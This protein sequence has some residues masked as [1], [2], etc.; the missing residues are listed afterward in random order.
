MLPRPPRST[1]TD[2]L[3][4]YTTLFRSGGIDHDAGGLDAGFLD[5]VDELAFMV[6]LAEDEA[7]GQPVAGLAAQGLDVG[8]GGAAI[9]FRL[10]LAQKVQVGTVQNIGGRT[11][12]PRAARRLLPLLCHASICSIRPEPARGLAVH[13]RPS[14]GNPLI[15]GADAAGR[16]EDRK[17][18]RLNSSH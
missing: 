4:P 18:T 15:A 10:A 9:N 11:D 8:E 2:T 1:R 13:H 14:A 7:E 3:F 17:S 12:F 16:A 5:P 6:A